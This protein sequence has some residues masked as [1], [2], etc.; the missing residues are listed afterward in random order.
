[1]QHLEQRQGLLSAAPLSL[2][3]ALIFVAPLLLVAA[4]SL[5][6]PNV[7]TIL[8]LPTFSNYR[9][10][11]AEGYYQSLLWSLG[12]AFLSTTVVFVL[13]YPLAYGMAKVFHRFTLV[14]TIGIVIALLVSEN[15]RV[16]GWV[17]TLMKGGLFLG[18]LHAWMGISLD[19]P[20]YNVPI[21]VF[22][23]AYSYFPFMLFPLCYGIAT[24]PDEVRLAASDLGA[25]RTRIFFEI[26]LPLAMPGIV[27]G[28]L[29]T[30]ALAAGSITESKLLSGQA[31]IVAAQE[32]ET[33][34]TYA[35]DWPLGSALA[36]GLIVI[37]SAIA[38][39]A[40]D[41]VDLDGIMGR[42]S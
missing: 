7:F 17:L 31:V 42:R 16:F 19:S 9:T 40:L 32:I 14:L 28:W 8:H 21:I 37:V 20:L 22:G 6:P 29:L 41:K 12:L 3:L 26:D 13:C 34:F 4:F 35:Q 30:F 39:I 38:F 1:M 25:S 23:L 2:L 33:A 18:P 15:I 36:M 24:I 27:V 10:L 11:F 5:M